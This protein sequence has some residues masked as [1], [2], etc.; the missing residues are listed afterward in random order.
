MSQVLTASVRA[1]ARTRALPRKAALV[2]TQT[3]VGKV[4]ELISQR[5]NAEALRVGVRSR[6]CSGLTYTLDFTNEK[7]KFDETVTQDGVTIF[8]DMKA[9]MTLLGTEMD[10]V[11]DKLSS[12]FVFNNPNVT[13][14]CGCGQSF[15]VSSASE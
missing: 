2:L 1:V 9:Q 15:M 13:G 14:T 10:Y 7:K 8:I 12:E 11:E 4:K 6:G 5:P 3:A